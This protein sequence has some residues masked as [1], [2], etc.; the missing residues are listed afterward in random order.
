[1]KLRLESGNN[2]TGTAVTVRKRLHN[3]H[4]KMYVAMSLKRTF[5]Y[6]ETV[7][8]QFYSFWYVLSACLSLI[9]SWMCCIVSSTTDQCFSSFLSLILLWMFLIFTH[10]SLSPVSG[11]VR[12]CRLFRPQSWILAVDFTVQGQQSEG[13]IARPHDLKHGRVKKFWWEYYITLRPVVYSDLYV[14]NELFFITN[15][16]SGFHIRL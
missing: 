9:Y 15:I 5:L 4:V 3:T 2:W 10:P 1:M 13:R 16:L 14:L 8:Y 11:C 12:L 7:E 6:V